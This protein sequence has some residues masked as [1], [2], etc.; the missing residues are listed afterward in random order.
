[1]FLKWGYWDITLGVPGP[2]FSII[3][4]SPTDNTMAAIYS[5]MNMI[6]VSFHVDISTTRVCSIQN[7]GKLQVKLVFCHVEL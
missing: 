1:M 5:N 6:K 4:S 2:Y 7:W 3:S